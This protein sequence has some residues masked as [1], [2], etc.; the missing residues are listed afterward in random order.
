M[1][2]R[3]FFLL[4]FLTL[5]GT[6]VSAQPSI[7][8][9]AYVGQ[10]NLNGGFPEKLLSTRTA[11]FHSVALTEAELNS[12]QDYFQRTGID[13][14]AYFPFDLLTSG[15]DAATGFHAFLVKREITNLVFAEKRDGM[16]RLTITVFD[17]GK[18][19][20]IIEANQPAWSIS[21]RVLVEALK[22]LNRSALATL[23]RKNL[24]IND[25]P[26]TDL[27]IDVVRGKRNEFYAVDMKVDLV[28]VQKFG[29]DSLDAQLERIFQTHFP[30][31][32]KMVEPG[33]SEREMRKQGMLYTLC[34][35]HARADAVRDLLGY[36]MRQSESAFVSITYSGDQQ[37]AKTIS[38]NRPVFKVYFK[39][40]DSGNVFLGTKWDAD[41]TWQQALINNIRA[42]KAELRLN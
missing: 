29:V 1:D 7:T 24:L 34:F 22:N 30:F 2:L 42:M 26:E 9:S 39:H 36:P 33:V 35:M 38:G 32:Y 4:A 13:A 40:I 6:L 8:E 15:K 5:M 25:F 41:L 27:T 18:D 28:G 10:L 21:D 12:M 19:G 17:K 3:K 11:V 31:A 16:F 14:V 37:Q 23:Q 20:K